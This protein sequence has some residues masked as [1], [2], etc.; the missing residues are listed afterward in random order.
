L[1]KDSSK[2]LEFIAEKLYNPKTAYKQ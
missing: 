1:K 2:E